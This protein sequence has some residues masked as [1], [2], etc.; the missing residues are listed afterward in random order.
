MAHG[1]GHGAMVPLATAHLHLQ[2]EV[3]L[4]AM[5]PGFPSWAKVPVDV[6]VRQLIAD[7]GVAAN[8]IAADVNVEQVI[9][10]TPR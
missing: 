1:V 2:L 5:E 7:F 3:D 6:N 8:A 10:D 4:H 9:K